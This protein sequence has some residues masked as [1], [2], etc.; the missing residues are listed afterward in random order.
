MW[1]AS[2]I[3]VLNNFTICIVRIHQKSKYRAIGAPYLLISLLSLNF[4]ILDF[5]SAYSSFFGTVFSKENYISYERR[6]EIFFGNYFH[7]IFCV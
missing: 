2:N 5:K 4:E 6:N 7:G 3:R 1:G